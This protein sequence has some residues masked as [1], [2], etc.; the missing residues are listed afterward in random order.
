MV[1][2]IQ[3]DG[4]GMSAVHLQSLIERKFQMTTTEEGT[5]GT[6]L[7]NVHRRIALRYGNQYG[8]TIESN[9]Q[10]GTTIS[11]TLPLIESHHEG[12]KMDA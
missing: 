5:G 6:G 8:V 10:Q 1:I 2:Q 3:D 12:R 4:A 9:L 11:L 7:M